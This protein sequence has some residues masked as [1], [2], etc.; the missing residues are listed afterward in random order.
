MDDTFAALSR[1]D[2][3]VIGY[4]LTAHLF[5]FGNDLIGRTFGA[6]AASIAG[7]AQIVDHDSGPAAGQF[8]RV[9]APQTRTGS[10]DDRHAVLKAHLI[11]CGSATQSR[12]GLPEVVDKAALRVSPFAFE[13]HLYRQANFQVIEFAIRKISR[14]TPTTI[15]LHH[16]VNGRRVD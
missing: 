15:E 16:P 4:R 5:D 7:T 8:Q 1:G 9:G 11:L 2:I 14:Q 6:F 12:N 10:G 13:S 3:I